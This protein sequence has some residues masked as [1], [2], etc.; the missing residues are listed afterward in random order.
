ML[1][2]SAIELDP[3]T[4][5]PDFVSSGTDLSDFSAAV[6]FDNPVSATF[7]DFSY[8]VKFRES[9]DLYHVV[10]INSAGQVRYLEGSRT[11]EHEDTDPDSFTVVQV[12][13]YS[14]VITSGSGSNSMH[15]TVAG[16]EAWLFVNNVFVDRFPVGG[17]GVSSDVQ[18][19]AELE[20]ETQITSAFTRLTNPEVRSGA[21]ADS[22]AALRMVKEADE[23]T[24]TG[25]TG[26]TRDFLIEAEFISGYE[27]ILG[28]WSIGFEFA[29]P[30]TGSTHWIVVNNSKR[31]NHYRQSEPGAQVELIAEGVHNGILRDRDD[32][33]K[34]QVLGQNGIQQLFINGTFVSEVA[35][36]PDLIPVQLS[37]ISGFLNTH[38][39]PD[40]PTD[41]QNYSVWSFGS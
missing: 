2:E 40:F 31:W 28:E 24:R 18:F 3:E 5:S 26:T 16:D 32:I 10:S 9:E 29:E 34:L 17:A 37:A 21:L 1:E 35:L 25:Q 7:R 36:Q 19:V 30:A 33:N 13:D 41:L 22:I 20:N 14:D 6:T 23:I 4:V 15:L 39:E 38:Q 12:F 8:G 11:E 27:R